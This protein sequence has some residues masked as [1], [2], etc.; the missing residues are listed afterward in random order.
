MLLVVKY[1]NVCSFN[2]VH[3]LNTKVNV[4][5]TDEPI[6]TNLKETLFQAKAKRRRG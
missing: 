4:P 1:G 5:K 3:V 6:P 2:F